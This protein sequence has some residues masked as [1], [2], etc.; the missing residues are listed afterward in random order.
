MTQ[1]A[2]DPNDGKRRG[3]G[4]SGNVNR[5]L[6]GLYMACA[7]VFAADFFY[8]KSIHFDPPENVPA[9][10]ALYGFVAFVVI[11]LGGKLLRLIVKRDEDFYDR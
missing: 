7:A 9:F 4:H 1:R 8:A 6:W 2:E 5:L 3:P 11:V 10:Y